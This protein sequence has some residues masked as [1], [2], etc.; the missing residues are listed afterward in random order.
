MARHRRRPPAPPVPRPPLIQPE[1]AGSAWGILRRII[2][3]IAAAMAVAF[4]L[5]DP[6]GADASGFWTIVGLGAGAAGLVS[7]A[8][9]VALPVR[10]VLVRERNRSTPPEKAIRRRAAPGSANDPSWADVAGVLVPRTIGDAAWA[11]L[12]ATVGMAIRAAVSIAGSGWDS[13]SVGTMISTPIGVFVVFVS[14]LIVGWLLVVAVRG[15][16]LLRA[17]PRGDVPA[18]AW[19]VFGAVAAIAIAVPVTLAV[20]LTDT[21]TVTGTGTDIIVAFFFGAVALSAPWQVVALWVARLASYAF[22]VCVIAVFVARWRSRA[23]ARGRS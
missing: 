17:L 19:W 9:I 21:T 14:L 2:V 7:A 6:A 10:A 3:G 11:V 16:V 15:F 23:R 12:V 18:S 8:R 1:W 5:I 4:W 20:G 22:V 13:A